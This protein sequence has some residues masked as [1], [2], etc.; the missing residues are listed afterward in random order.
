ML[1]ISATSLALQFQPVQEL[2]MNIMSAD[3]FVNY[4]VGVVA[5]SIALSWLGASLGL[6]LSIRNAPLEK[7]N[8]S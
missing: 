6:Y 4:F 1:L 2:F 5:T 7:R 3:S 8:P